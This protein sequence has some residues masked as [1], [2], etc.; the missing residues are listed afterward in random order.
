MTTT[1]VIYVLEARDEGDRRAFVSDLLAIAHKMADLA[2]AGLRVNVQDGDVDWGDCVEHHPALGLRSAFGPFEAVAQLWLDD[3]NDAALAPFETLLRTVT[4]RVHGY[5]VDERV[6]VHNLR[7]SAVAG[8]R[9][10]GY[11]QMALLQI[12]ER[13]TRQQWLSAWQDRHTWVALSIHPHLEYIQNVVVR[14]VTP[15]APPISGIGEEAF[16]MAGLHDERPLFRGGESDDAKYEE[17]HTIMYEDASRFIDF[18]HLD[19]IVSSQ[20]DLVQPPR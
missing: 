18:D 8:G 19:M 4:P 16:P 17:L 12:P 3:A 13:L 1:K 2:P 7:Q 10:D 6:L 9:N 11:S 5:L 15:D 14:A 20:F